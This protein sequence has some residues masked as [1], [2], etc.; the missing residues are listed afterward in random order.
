MIEDQV[1]G[2]I[3]INTCAKVVADSL[4]QNMIPLAITTAILAVAFGVMAILW[5]QTNREEKLAKDYLRRRNGL[6]DYETWKKDR[7]MN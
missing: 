2:V 6:N 4:Q 7:G 5:L 3:D 1:V